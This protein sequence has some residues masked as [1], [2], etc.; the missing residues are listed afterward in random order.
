MR[1]KNKKI[2]V[3]WLLGL[4]LFINFS[5]FQSNNF[6]DTNYSDETVIFD[7]LNRKDYTK[8]A[9]YWELTTPIEID[10]AGSNNWTWAEGESWFGGGNGTIHNPYII[11]NVTIDVNSNYDFCIRV[12]NSNKY[13]IIRNC[14]VSKAYLTGIALWNVNNSKIIN[15]YAFSNSYVGIGLLDSYNNSISKNNVTGNLIGGI[16][17][18]NS[19][20]NFI[21]ENIANSND[22]YGIGLGDCTNNTISNNTA[23]YNSK[24]GIGLGDCTNNT[25]S[26]NTANYNSY[27][28]IGLLSSNNNKISENNVTSNSE[29]GIG[30]SLSD[31]NAISNNTANNNNKYGISLEFSDNNII[32]GNSLYYNSIGGI[33]I[34]YSDDNSVLNNI[35]VHN[36]D[37]G[38]RLYSSDNTIVSNNVA[39]S[40]SGHG[41]YLY[42]SYDNTISQNTLNYNSAMGDGIYLYNSYDNTISQNSIS[43][44]D[45]SGIS[46]RYS[47]YNYISFNTV[48]NH[49]YGIHLY[50]SD[51][52]TITTNWI[53]YNYVGIYLTSNSYYN[54]VSDNIFTGNDED[55]VEVREQEEQGGGLV[56]PVYIA[57][58][59]GLVII[60]IIIAGMMTIKRK[61]LKSRVIITEKYSPYKTVSPEKS[62][63]EGVIE[64]REESRLVIRS[65]EGELDVSQDELEVV[66]N[67]SQLRSKYKDKIVEIREYILR[68]NKFISLEG[69]DE[70]LMLMEKLNLKGI[71]AKTIDIFL[72]KLLVYA[73]TH[74]KYARLINDT[75]IRKAHRK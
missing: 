45:G 66:S 18:G 24:S 74:S 61:K 25:I 35:A 39:S 58:G 75:H 5:F 36:D 23:N 13:F 2:L 69:I 12:N 43:S 30:L 55:I 54:F 72:E 10:D 34:Q 7:K 60:C 64:S 9:A 28:G 51:S 33:F 19:C 46:L 50:G 42:N 48:T 3:F 21:I 62:M 14:T 17:L 37:Y 20:Y 6:N 1:L 63:R 41:I 26:N 70:I 49:S 68:K 65:E 44:N 8:T 27:V 71:S 29:G 15:N 53:N 11:E 31:Y 16:G 67:I 38:I 40:N 22:G 57:I 32:S 59:I 4:S 52:N 47:D 56:N 73:I